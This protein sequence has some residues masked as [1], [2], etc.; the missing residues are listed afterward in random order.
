MTIDRRP[1]NRSIRSS[2]QDLSKDLTGQALIL[3]NLDNSGNLTWVP[4]S[5]LTMV[6]CFGDDENERW[7]AIEYYYQ[8]KQVKR[9][10]ELFLKKGL[11]VQ[12]AVGG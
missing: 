1:S 4:R 6:E 11:E 9:S 8:G 10:L 3:C 12:L 5:E 2:Q 7:Y